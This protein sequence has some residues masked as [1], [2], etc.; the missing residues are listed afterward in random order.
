MP[1][2]AV[3]REH[4]SVSSTSAIKVKWLECSSSRPGK[5]WQ[6]VISH[7]SV[8]GLFVIHLGGARP[9][10]L[11][12]LSEAGAGVSAFKGAVRSPSPRPSCLFSFH[13][14][15]WNAVGTGN[16]LLPLLNW[17]VKEFLDSSVWQ[18]FSSNEGRPPRL[19]GIG[20]SCEWKRVS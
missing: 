19:P 3:T 20:Y 9:G 10:C 18:A 17:D 6:S 11:L 13:V 16:P 2:R 7:S 14:D 1:H 5:K 4:I 12:H 8:G 15:S